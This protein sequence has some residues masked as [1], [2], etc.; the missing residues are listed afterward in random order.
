MIARALLLFVA[1]ALPL[2]SHAAENTAP[3]PSL[4]S[5]FI[6]GDSTA[7]NGNPGAVGWGRM[8]GE[9]F[10]PAKVNLV[11]RARGG[12]SSR[13][14]ITEGLWDQLMGEVQAGDIVLIQFGHNDVGEINDDRRARGSL[15]GLGD[16]TEEIDNQ[17]TKRHEVVHTF[18]W[19]LRKMVEDVQARNAQPIVIALTVRN[20]WE[21]GRVERGLSHYA[22][23]SQAVA[24]SAKVPFVDLTTIAADRYEAMGQESAAA[25]FPRDHTH[26]SAAGA[27]LN[28][29]LIVAGLKGLD[30]VSIS[31]L[32][33]AQGRSVS[34]IAPAHQP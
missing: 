2:V 25:L 32:F 22:E 26:T 31:P 23:W 20:I 13:T 11:N 28:A 30:D 33:S 18:G 6:A 15:P 27:A 5:I 10:D 34:A 12:R 7:A 3:N 24:V 8:V 16:E 19:Y 4:P 21:N 29:E 14:F 17:I 1:P 9:F